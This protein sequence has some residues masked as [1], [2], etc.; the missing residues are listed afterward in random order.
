[1]AVALTP[2]SS[3]RPDVEGGFGVLNLL[4]RMRFSIFCIFA[5]ERFA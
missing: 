4:A 2:V 1:M 5:S 3:E